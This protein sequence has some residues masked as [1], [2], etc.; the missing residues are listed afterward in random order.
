MYFELPERPERLTGAPAVPLEIDCA[1]LADYRS[2][3]Q[4]HR[5]LDVREAWETAICGFDES[6]KVPMVQIA[7]RAA[8]LPR[9]G[10]LVV[11][12]HHGRRSLQVANWLRGQGFTGATSLSG[13]I[14]AWATEFDP[15]MA[16][17]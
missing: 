10:T 1:T 14:D 5:V 6:L 15:E 4:P 16:R 7:G 13:G 3:G 12:C 17:Y 2:Q 8:E 9:D 11:L